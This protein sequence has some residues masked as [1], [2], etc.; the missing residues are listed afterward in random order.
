MHFS[1]NNP[2]SKFSVPFIRNPTKFSGILKFCKKHL[3]PCNEIFHLRSTWLFWSCPPPSHHLYIPYIYVIW[4]STYWSSYI[5]LFELTNRIIWG[6]SVINNFSINHKTTWI[7]KDRMQQFLV[8]DLK[9]NWGT[10]L[11]F[12]AFLTSSALVSFWP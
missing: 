10:I 1:W 7:L 5:Y 6:T 12:K 11:H 4:Y 8:F 9:E 3:F 2:K